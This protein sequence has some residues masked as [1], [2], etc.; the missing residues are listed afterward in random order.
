MTERLYYTDAYKAEF[1]SEVKTCVSSK[2]RF[3]A[4]LVATAF[5][6][7]GG[8][9]PHDIGELGGRKVLD[10][11]DREGE[12][13]AHVID[14]PL[15]PGTKVRGV[16]DWTRRF[17]HM[18]QHSGQHLLSA[19]FASVVRARTESFHL[20]AEASTI[21]LNR[22]VSPSEIAAAEDEVNSVV[23][24]DREV[25]VCFAAADDASDLALR[26]ESARTG[27]LRLIDMGGFDRS[28]CGGTHVSR[29]GA[30]GLIAVTG[31][32]KFKGGT[33][34]EFLCGGRALRRLRTWRDVF[35][36][37]SRVLSVL[38]EG[39]AP[40]IERLQGENKALGRT[41]REMQEQLAGH[42]AKEL[43]A[44]G[45]RLPDG[46]TVVVQ[47]LDGWDAPGLK[48]IAGAAAASPGVC[49]A[50]FSGSTP[51]L[52]VIARAADVKSPDAAQTL[53]ALVARFGGKGG[54]KP[55][56]A[57]GGGLEGNLEE[58]VRAARDLLG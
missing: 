34:I 44:R 47:A 58:I 3:V 8:G 39:L 27:T 56:F 53:K 18:Q 52:T 29:T 50:V 38:P 42:Q 37:T 28:A 12:G 31:W 22:L 24:A 54:G 35:A 21:D 40:A 48:A 11:V 55:E 26:K 25:Q 45:Q 49:V 5:Y 17:D 19:A 7:T 9:Q 32:E 2:D 20:G 30:V 1:E 6:P 41:V 10:V 15:E 16:I 4:T 14:G 36:A 57:Q 23:W 33:R 43:V 13:V 51:A 46:R